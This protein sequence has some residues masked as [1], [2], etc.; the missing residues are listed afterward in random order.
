MLSK[1]DNSQFFLLIWNI[2]DSVIHIKKKY[3]QKLPNE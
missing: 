3:K 1:Q 2:L